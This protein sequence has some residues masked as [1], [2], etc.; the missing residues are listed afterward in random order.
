MITLKQE[1]DGDTIEIV[2][3]EDSDI[4]DTFRYIT[5]FLQ[6]MT[7]NNSVIYHG[8]LAATEEIEEVLACDA[9]TFKEEVLNDTQA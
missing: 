2:F 4:F 3:S 6:A 5:V 1:R 9:N 8:L 7:Y